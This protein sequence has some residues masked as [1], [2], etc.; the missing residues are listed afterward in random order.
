MQA[1][2]AETFL[3]LNAS[4]NIQLIIAAALAV[5]VV[6]K[7]RTAVVLAPSVYYHQRKFLAQEPLHLQEPQHLHS[8]AQPFRLQSRARPMCV[9]SL[10]DAMSS[11]RAGHRLRLT[12]DK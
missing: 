5:I 12:I 8:Y 11:E 6:A 2:T 4:K 10:P 7:A 9:R 1:P 3:P